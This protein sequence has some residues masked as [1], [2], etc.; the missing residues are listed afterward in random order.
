MPATGAKDEAIHLYRHRP[1]HALGELKWPFAEFWAILIAFRPLSTNDLDHC[2]TLR[3]KP[4]GLHLCTWRPGVLHRAQS[5]MSQE[6]V[7]SQSHLESQA[8]PFKMRSRCRPNLKAAEENK[9]P[10]QWRTLMILYQFQISRTLTF[11]SLIKTSLLAKRP[12]RDLGLPI[13]TTRLY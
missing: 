4:Y 9:Q 6:S 7:K 8:I 12:L 1:D 3:A 2:Q 11:Q 10:I 13:E 5:D